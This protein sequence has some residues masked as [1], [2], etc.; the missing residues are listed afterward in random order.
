MYENRRTPPLSRALYLRR[1]AL[2]A[3]VATLVVGVSLGGGVLGYRFFEGL[4]WGEAFL[5]AAVLLGGMGLVR[6]PITH[7]GK[8]FAAVYALYAGLVFLAVTGILFAPVVHRLLHLFHW[9]GDRE[10]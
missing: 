8:L 3:A 10:D 7:G 6:V 5:H 9:E 4:A 2:H 1:V